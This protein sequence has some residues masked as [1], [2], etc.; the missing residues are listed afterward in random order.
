MLS[1]AV[2]SFVTITFKPVTFPR[3]FSFLLSQPSAETRAEKS[4]KAITI[5]QRNRGMARDRRED[6]Q[7]EPNG[8]GVVP[9]ALSFYR[10]WVYSYRREIV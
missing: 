2:L 10:T 3:S 5:A 9:S 8:S 6:R 7:R 4:A 1:S